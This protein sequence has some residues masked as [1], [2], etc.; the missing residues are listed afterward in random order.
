MKLRN[1]AVGACSEYI[2]VP[3]E[4]LTPVPDG[5]DPAEA[6]SLV[7]SYVTAYQMLHR[8]ARVKPGGRILVHGAGGAVGTAMIQLC[9]LNNIEVYGT[10]SESKHELVAGLG[11]VPV[12]YRKE[13]FVD[14]IGDLVQEGV[15]AVFDPIGGENLKRSFRTLKPGGLLVCYGFYNSVMGKGGSIPLD[16]MRLKLWSILP[17]QRSATFYSI[18]A[19]REKHPEWFTEDLTLL[20]DLLENKKIRPVIGGRFHMTEAA[21]AYERIEIGEVNGKMI[22]EVS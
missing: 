5:V 16:F 6:V 19:T 4:R 13:D 2:C 9:R 22:L 1:S 8:I 20:F 12:D 17:N 3:A 15:D 7:L 18:G 10:A 14:R 11:A 21:K